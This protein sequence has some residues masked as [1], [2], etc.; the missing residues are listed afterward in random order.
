MIDAH[1]ILGPAGSGKSTLLRTKYTAE[2]GQPKFL[3]TATT[4]VAALNLGDGCTTLNSLLKFFD[5]DSLEKNMR[6][7]TWAAKLYR[8][9][10]HSGVAGLIVDEVSM[11]PAK[12]LDLLTSIVA[13]LNEWRELDGLPPMKLILSGDLLQLPPVTRDNGPIPYPFMAQ[14][15]PSVFQPK[16]EILRKIWRQADPAFQQALWYARVGDGSNCAALLRAQGVRFI[17]EPFFAFNGFSIYP[18]KA[19]SE[20]HNV[21]RLK[22]LPGE[23]FSILAEKWGDLTYCQELKEIPDAVGFKVNCRVRF[24]ANS[25]GLTYV[26]GMLGTLVGRSESGQPIVQTSEGQEITVPYHFRVHYRPATQADQHLYPTQSKSEWWLE[27]YPE[28]LQS[29]TLPFYNPFTDMVA[30]AVAR[31]IPLQLGYSATFHKVQG[32]QF[33]ELQIDVRNRFAGNPQMMYVALSRMTS[34]EGAV[35]VGDASTLARRIQT[36]WEL[37]SFI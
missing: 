23:G 13:T 18:T 16:V 1:V 17:P 21:N 33:S 10:G 15:W 26:N 7:Q 32:L 27:K 35:I 30:T 37:R 22:A 14:C 3:M 36:A 19:S 29:R 20:I 12:T 8:E 6:S 5:T 9:I 24:T 11:M 28:L 25:S 2:A 4:G 34:V 31:Y